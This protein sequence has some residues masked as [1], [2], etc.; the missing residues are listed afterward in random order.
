MELIY[1]GQSCFEVKMSEGLVLIDPFITPNPLVE[2]KDISGLKPEYILITHGHGD[3]TFDA[4]T[5]A[6]NSG[7]T[8]V[9]NYEITTWYSSRGIERTHGMNIGGGY[10][11]PFGYLKMVNAIHSSSMPDGA[12]GGNPAGYVIKNSS[13]TFYH[14][15]DTS[16][17]SDMSLIG[18]EF[19]LDFAI[20]PIGDNF[21]M[22]IDDALVSAELLGTNTV[23]AMHFDTFP[24]I[25]IDKEA[26]L[27]K[28]EAKGIK[29][30]IPKIGESVIF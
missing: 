10:K 19:E 18:K 2:N 23:V 12:Y 9:S 21:T 16:L 13:K 28:A 1:H 3:H 17:F 22:G 7:A 15:G 6:A 20:L 8:I 25:E 30:I 4:E 27:A 26:C 24:V 29:L 14:A 11:F 5:I